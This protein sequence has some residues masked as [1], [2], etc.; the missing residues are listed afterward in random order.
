MLPFGS[1]A[2]VSPHT[3]QILDPLHQRRH[4][5]WQDACDTLAVGAAE[6]NLLNFLVDIAAI[7][8]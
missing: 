6:G 4:E 3:G 7:R 5:T 2:V 1:S 8:G